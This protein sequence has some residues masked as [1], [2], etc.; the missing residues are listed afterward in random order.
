[1]RRMAT[2][3]LQ[4]GIFK[5]A[6]AG[7]QAGFTIEQMIWLLNVGITGESLLRRI[8]WRFASPETD[9]RSSRLVM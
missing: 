4:G 9:A 2:R 6:I 3:S 7:E 1:V 8:E 5:L